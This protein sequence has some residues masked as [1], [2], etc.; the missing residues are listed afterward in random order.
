M[1]T[2]KNY[3]LFIILAIL[4]TGAWIYS[5][6]YQKWQAEQ[7]NADVQ[8]P[9]G[10]VNMSLV[11]KIEITDKNKV[12]H[13]VKKENDIWLYGEEKWPAEKILIDNLEKTISNIISSE[14]EKVSINPQKKSNFG[15]TD[16]SI[17]LKLFQGDVM[18]ADFIIGN[19]SS[20]YTSTYISKENDDNTYSVPEVL[21]GITDYTNWP[22]KTITNLQ[23]ESIDTITLAYPFQ[24]IILTDKPAVSGEVYWRSEKPYVVRLSKDKIEA[25]LLKAGKLEAVALSPQTETGTGLD[26]P[27]LSLSLSG[28]GVNEKIIIGGTD[29]IGQY[30]LKQETTGRIFLITKAN[31]DELFKQI[32]DFQ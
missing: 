7:K 18:M 11:D 16:K 25:F 21:I 32:K 26:K 28:E 2:K 14:P 23:T 4:T 20:D 30:Y 9:V 10:D 13:F 24:N 22:D 27:A 19:T 6:P 8:N 12:A 1:F 29:A 17:V 31:K 3:T 15:I 5:V